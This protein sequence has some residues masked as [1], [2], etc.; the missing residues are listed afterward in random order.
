VLPL[1]QPGEGFEGPIPVAATLTVIAACAASSLFVVGLHTFISM[2]WASFALNVGI[3]LGGILYALGVL[4]TRQARF[5]PWALPAL[6]HKIA[7]PWICG[8]PGAHS[9]LRSLTASIAIS[10]GGFVLT[11]VAG[12]WLLSR[13]DVF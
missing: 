9:E 1:L 10:V 3:A 7:V 4:D 12:G 5:I 13:R 11:A 2:R 8:L 6:A